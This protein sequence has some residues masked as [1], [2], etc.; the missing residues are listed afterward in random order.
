LKRILIALFETA[1]C[2]VVSDEMVRIIKK[3]NSSAENGA[4]GE[5]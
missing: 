1:K 2:F 3:S 5:K 4:G